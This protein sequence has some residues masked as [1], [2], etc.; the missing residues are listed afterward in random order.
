MSAQNTPPA[1]TAYPARLEVDYTVDHNRVTTLF[2]L[3]L[4]I[5]IA[6]VYGALTAAPPARS[7]TRGAARP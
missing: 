3:V 6:I 2:R 1:P 5:P 7:T 4:V